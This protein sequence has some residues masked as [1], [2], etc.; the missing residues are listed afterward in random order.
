MSGSCKTV[1]TSIAKLLQ[2]LHCGILLFA[3]VQPCRGRCLFLL[4]VRWLARWYWNSLNRSKLFRISLWDTV[5]ESLAVN[6]PLLARRGKP[7][8]KEPQLIR[9]LQVGPGRQRGTLTSLKESFPN[10]IL[11][12]RLKNKLH[13]SFKLVRSYTSKTHIAEGSVKRHFFHPSSLYY[14]F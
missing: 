6:V 1:A 3:T 9:S 11:L 13:P 14:R 5:R 4:K 7:C 2:H 12:V 10:K 8:P